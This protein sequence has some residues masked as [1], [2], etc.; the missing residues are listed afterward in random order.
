MASEAIQRQIATKWQG[1]FTRLNRD[2][3][4]ILGLLSFSEV[5]IPYYTL[6]KPYT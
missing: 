3:P 4:G 2:Q 5:S 6:N 1:S